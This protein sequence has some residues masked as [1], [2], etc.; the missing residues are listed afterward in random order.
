MYGQIISTMGSFGAL[1]KTLI[2]A[3]LKAKVHQH[4]AFSR[5]R[6]Q[7]RLSRNPS[8][9]DFMTHIVPHVGRPNGITDNEV[10][11]NAQILI[12]AGSETSATLLSGTSYFLMTNPGPYQKL[13]DEIRSAF[14]SEEEINFNSISK[15][16]YTLAVL[17]ESMRMH[18]PV[19]AGIHRFVPAGGAMIDGQ[20]VA[21]GTDVVVHQWAAYRSEC[22]F[23]D[24]DQF[25]P[26]RWLGEDE[27]YAGDDRAVFNPFSIGPRA[28]IGRGLA[29]MEMR[30]VLARLV[31]SFDMELM[32]E[33]EG[34]TDQK[35]WVLYEKEP[36][37]AKLAEVKRG[38]QQ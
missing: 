17:H 3:H 30:L 25:I 9:P 31:W 7:Q 6:V 24:S 14:A 29:Y 27:R 35:C 13:K 8:R 38:S 12:M 28:C 32:K 16:K 34:W 11:A 22:N 15:L 36:L 21:G 1:L 37:M 5:S 4:A 26:E 23:R 20:W 2:P 19:P 10:L 33:S 18:P